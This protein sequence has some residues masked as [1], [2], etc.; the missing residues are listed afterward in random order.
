MSATVGNLHELGQ[1]LDAQ[2]YAQNFR[3]VELIEYIKCQD[4]VYKII[5]DHDDCKFIFERSLQY[6]VSDVLRKLTILK[7]MF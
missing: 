7:N 1:F 4:K 6:K 2:V 3:P 5:R